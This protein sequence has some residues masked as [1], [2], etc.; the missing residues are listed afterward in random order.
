MTEDAPARAL[1]AVVR[2]VWYLGWTLV[3][4][5]VLWWRYRKL[6]P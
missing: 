5:I 4:G 1:P 2:V 3:P 6:T